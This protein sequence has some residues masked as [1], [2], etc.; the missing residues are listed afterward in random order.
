MCIFKDV[1]FQKTDVV[2]VEE[3][4]SIQL[5]PNDAVAISDDLH[6]FEFVSGQVC[7]D[8]VKAGT[9][10]GAIDRIVKEQ[11]D[12]CLA[13]NGYLQRFRAEV[14]IIPVVRIQKCD[15]F[16]SCDADASVSCG[17]LARVGLV[18]HDKPAIRG[19]VFVENGAG[20]IGADWPRNPDI[21]ADTL[22]RCRRV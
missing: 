16:P 1:A 15:V 4:L 3:C 13:F 6:F 11:N 2:L 20:G 10:V 8:L 5:I 18:N 17:R 9:T 22:R 14:P 12:I 21:A 19:G 7:P